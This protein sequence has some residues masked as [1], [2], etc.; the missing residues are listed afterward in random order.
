M[1]FHP[2]GRY[3]PSVEKVNATNKSLLAK[4]KEQIE[5]RT[6]EH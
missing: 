3:R 1:L 2:A 4:I 5:Y 6:A